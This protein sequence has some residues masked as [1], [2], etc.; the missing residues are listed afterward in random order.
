MSYYAAVDDIAAKPAPIKGNFC[1][2]PGDIPS[3][4]G[5]AR[6]SVRRPWPCSGVPIRFNDGRGCLR[7]DWVRQIEG[8]KNLH[9]W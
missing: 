2:D 8:E 6:G 5:R 1:K 9:C 4:V 7:S 3:H